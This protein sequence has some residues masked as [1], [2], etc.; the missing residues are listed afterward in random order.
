MMERARLARATTLASTLT[1]A[2]PTHN[3]AALVRDTLASVT[4][5]AIPAGVA[6]DCL[7]VDNASTDD[8]ARVIEDFAR[9][10]TLKMRLVSE[11]RLGSSFARNRAVDESASDYIFFID[12]DAI[13]ERDWATELLDDMR[14]RDLDAACG[15]VLPRWASPPPKWLRPGLWVTLTG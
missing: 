15:M 9:D 7:V 6:A 10:S 11:P 4:A 13:A 14:R 12:D 2:I 1:I 3:R 5:L 8:T